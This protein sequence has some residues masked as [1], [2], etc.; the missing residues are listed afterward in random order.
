MLSMD[1]NS[2][3]TETANLGYPN[4]QLSTCIYNN[5]FWGIPKFLVIYQFKITSL[6]W[7]PCFLLGIFWRAPLFGGNLR[8]IDGDWGVLHF[9][10]PP[11]FPQTLHPKLKAISPVALR[12]AEIRCL[13]WLQE[14]A[15]S[16]WLIF[17]I[18]K[19]VFVRKIGQPHPTT[20]N[21]PPKCT[22]NIWKVN[23][24]RLSNILRPAVLV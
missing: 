9:R 7:K 20:K 23:A 8:V 24:F 21:Q 18:S 1:Q 2:I 4:C 15:G 13:A 3:F 11:H 5:P 22:W 16:C 10:T 12:T 6:A 19:G 17:P 14:G